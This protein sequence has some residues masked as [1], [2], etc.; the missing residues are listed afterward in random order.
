M[1]PHFLTKIDIKTFDRAVEYLL[2]E[3]PKL[4]ISILLGIRPLRLEVI[5]S[6]AFGEFPGHMDQRRRSIYPLKP[7]LSFSRVDRKMGHVHE[8]FHKGKKIGSFQ[9]ASDAADYANNRYGHGS[10]ATSAQ[11]G[12]ALKTAYSLRRQDIEKFLAELPPQPKGGAYPIVRSFITNPD[13]PTWRTT[14][15]EIQSVQTVDSSDSRV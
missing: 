14:L 2:A 8:V 5:Y 9:S 1:N 10:A 11:I 13:I 12:E 4:E 15:L 6:M 7:N 3:M